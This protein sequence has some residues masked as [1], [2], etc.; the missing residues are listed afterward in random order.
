MDLAPQYNNL[1]SSPLGKDLLREL[2]TLADL[3]FREAGNAP[4]SEVAGLT[5]QAAG[6]MLAIEHLHSLAYL[7]KDEGSKASKH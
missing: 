5:K 1:L 6:I 3:R 7:P 2:N 4:D